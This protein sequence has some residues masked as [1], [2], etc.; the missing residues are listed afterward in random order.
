M[1]LFAMFLVRREAILPE[2]EKTGHY[3][4]QSLANPRLI[5]DGI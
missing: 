2:G 1:S 3:L 5:S 4:W